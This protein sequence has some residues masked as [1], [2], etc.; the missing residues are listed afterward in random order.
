MTGDTRLLVPLK[1]VDAVK[2]CG[3]EAALALEQAGPKSG[4]TGK[5]VLQVSLTVGAPFIS[6]FLH[7]RAPCLV[8]A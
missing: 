8:L 4:D 7:V 5:V 6:S 2:G 1:L 3:Y